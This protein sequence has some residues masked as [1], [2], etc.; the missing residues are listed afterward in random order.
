[1]QRWRGHG[2]LS[3]SAGA[4]TRRR[5]LALACGVLAS[6][7]A[8]PVA[9][10]PVSYRTDVT[11][12]SQAAPVALYAEETGEGPPI[13]LLHGLGESTFTW[14][15]IVPALA[16]T[17]RVIALDLK[18]FGRSDKP[19]DQAYSADDQ[20]ALVAAFMESRGLKGVVLIGHSFGG[21]VALRAALVPSVQEAGR[22]RRLVIISAPAL[23]RSVAPSLDLIEIPA[24]PDAFAAALPAEM[25]ARL[26]LREALGGTND[27]PEE[28]I[29]GYA[30]P[31]N[32]TGARHA[33]LATARS[34]VSETG[35]EIAARYRTISLPTLIIWCRKDEVVPLRAGK[36]LTRTIPNSRIAVLERCHHLPQDERPMALVELIRDFAGN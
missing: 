14:R 13:L 22:I 10:E 16:Q 19:L 9:A 27:I 12:S 20:A 5:G 34:I 18:G 21:T 23:P 17:H 35:D 25:M 8:G 4:T 7:C 11:A 28:D 1:M 32:D 3:R 30:A 24:V 2:R 31:Y 15:K 29:K 6:L 33:F 36:R 26:L